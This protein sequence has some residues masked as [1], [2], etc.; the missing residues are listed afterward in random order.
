[1]AVSFMTA[2]ELFFGA[3]KSAEPTA[4]ASL[5]DQFLLSVPVIGP[6]L[7]VLRLFG[8]IKA[9]LQAAGTPIADADV[10]IG[11][12]VLSCGARLITGNARHFERISGVVMENWI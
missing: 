2:A 8:S 6:D 3:A 11:A 9:D 7:S 10:F 1:V 4:N 5:V 12:T